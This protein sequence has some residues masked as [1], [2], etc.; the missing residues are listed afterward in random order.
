MVKKPARLRGETSR[1][2]VIRISPESGIRRGVIS[3]V[4]SVRFPP[5]GPMEPPVARRTKIS[6]SMLPAP[7]GSVAPGPN[8]P[9]AVVE[10]SKPFGAERVISPERL[11]ALRV[12]ETAS[13]GCVEI[14]RSPA[15]EGED[16][17]SKGVGITRPETETT[18]VSAAELARV[19]LPEREAGEV[20]EGILTWTSAGVLAAGIV[21]FEEKVLLSVD[22]TKPSGAVIKMTESRL[23]PFTVKLSTL[24]CS[25]SVVRN[26]GRL[27]TLGA[28]NG[29]T[30]VP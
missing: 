25:L 28:T 20:P 30:T 12:K 14:V 22:T 15:I 8:G 7:T 1:T 17:D 21:A 16:V 9:L 5:T 10:I 3:D 18:F 24:D 11:V 23:L 2:G 27:V 29:R 4:V 26:A 19:M 13:E 6:C